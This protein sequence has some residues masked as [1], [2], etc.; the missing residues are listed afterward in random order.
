MSDG[1]F[2]FWEDFHLDSYWF[3]QR[4]VTGEEKKGNASVFIEML[5][6]DGIIDP[7]YMVCRLSHR[8][9]YGKPL[10]DAIMQASF[11][12][13]GREDPDDVRF[14]PAI[15]VDFSATVHEVT[16]L[17]QRTPSPG[18]RM[19]ND[20]E[21]AG[22]GYPLN[23][24]GLAAQEAHDFAQLAADRAARDFEAYEIS[25]DRALRQLAREHLV[26][27][28]AA[29]PRVHQERIRLLEDEA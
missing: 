14:L 23:G 20:V 26:G 11:D 25:R 17:Q 16:R 22:L 2:W 9:G 15:G 1:H 13:L 7:A 18:F 27:G 28:V 3:I 24:R 4:P 10:R 19:D 8:A 29:L 5:N 21:F 6:E 12:S